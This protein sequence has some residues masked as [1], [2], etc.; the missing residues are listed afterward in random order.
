MIYFIHIRGF[1]WKPIKEALPDITFPYEDAEK[2]K[3]SKKTIKQADLIIAE[4][5]E[6]STGMGIEL[7]WANMLNKRIICIHKKGA[8]VS[9]S[10]NFISEKIIEYDSPENLISKIKE[11]ANG[12]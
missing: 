1:D 11:V 8:K 2:P 7:G 9:R 3:D 4:V 6:P 10:L 12:I 5:S